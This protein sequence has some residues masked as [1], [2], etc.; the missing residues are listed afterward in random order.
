MR[1]S[2]SFFLVEGAKP[3]VPANEQKPIPRRK[4]MTLVKTTLLG[5]AG[6]IL[7]FGLTA[8]QAQDYGGGE[9]GGQPPAAGTD[10]GA[11]GPAAEGGK[12]GAE[13]G[14]ETAKPSAEA[15]KAEGQAKEM[16]EE[17][18]GASAKDE[19]AGAEMKDEKAGAEMKDE[20]AGAEMKDEKAG[21]EMKDEKAG[22]TA[23][24]KA[25][26]EG[27]GKAAKID[28]QQIGKVKTYFSQ[29]KPNVKVV[30]KSEVNVSI[31]ILVPTA[32]VLYDLPPDI[33][34]VEGPCTVKYF[35][36]GEDVVLVDSCTRKVVEIIVIA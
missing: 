28:S 15:G 23:E 32:I 26:A 27:E 34:V 5:A 4:T 17:K 10:K 1:N 9:A 31:G 22:A 3:F 11:G 7:A 33:I 6:V 36:W 25:G 12:A 20:K 30:A 29:N 14:A 2:G 35:V 18:A 19:K 21:A 16:K 8:A 24:T 13:A